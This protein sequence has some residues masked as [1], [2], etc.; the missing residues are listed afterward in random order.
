MLAFRDDIEAAAAVPAL[1]A[2]EPLTVESLTAEL[3]SGWTDPGL[4]PR[5]GAWLLVEAGGDDPAA[6]R[7]HAARLAR[8]AGR[9]LR[10]RAASLI[11]DRRAQAT[12]WRVREDG[13]GRASRLPDG[14][15]AWPGFEDAAV[16]PER[17]AAYLA[18]LHGLLRDADLRGVT[19]GHFGEGCIHLRVGFGLDAPGGEARFRGFMDRAADLVVAHGGTLSGEHGDGRARSE[20]LARQFSPAMLAAFGEWKAIWDAAGLL[21]P[22]IIV[23]PAPFAVDL[24]RP[25]PT[26]LEPFAPGLAFEADG[27]DFRAAVERCIGVGRCVSTQGHALMC[28]SYRATGEERHS[29]RGR[30]RLLQEMAAGSLAADGWRSPEVHDALDLCLSCRACSTDCPT[31]VDMASYK[32]EVL[33]QRFRRPASA[34]QPLPPGR[35]PRWLRRIR[36]VPGG[37]GFVNALA[38]IAPTRRLIA[39]AGGLAGERRI[40][41]IAAEP[42]A[43]GSPTRRR[44]RRTAARSCCGRTRSRSTSRPPS[45]MP[46]CGSS[47]PP[48][49]TSRCRAARCAAA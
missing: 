12:L 28:P 43:T 25:R 1:V 33:H 5:G 20:L 8:A 42:S 23:D 47:R 30:A 16:P 44:P 49:S 17:L 4:L 18:A 27:G 40:P 36:R 14:S 35:L 45:A 24:R 31:G 10:S 6:M 37:V 32:S 19:Y 34:A 13:A 46:R 9:T 2:E 29:T 22:G 48:A 3:L 11:E 39:L 7:D 41:R 26:T 15:P 21:N 38:G